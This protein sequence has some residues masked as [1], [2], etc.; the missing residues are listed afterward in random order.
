PA[1][2]GEWWRVSVGAAVAAA[3]GPPGDLWA[4]AAGDGAGG[5]APALWRYTS[6]DGGRTWRYHGT[7][8][9]VRGWVADLARPTTAAAY[10]LATGFPGATSAGAG[11]VATGDRGATWQAR[12]DPCLAGPAASHAYPSQ[13]LAAT[14]TLSLWLLCGS[15]PT[16]G[17]RQAKLVERSSD[18]G[19][20]WKAVA[21]GLPAQGLLPA[22]GTTGEVVPASPLGALLVLGG[23]HQSLLASTGG[24]S[25]WTPAAPPVVEGQG[26][27]QVSAAGGTVFV[28]TRSALWASHAG[29]WREV[30]QQRSSW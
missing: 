18:G 14:S 13:A 28:L 12:P 24:G 19:R 16:A 8:P 22:A 3:G 9:R 6:V 25:R 5:G 7:L 20:T 23:R 17:G 4:L 15:N 26:P 1:G 27:I 10:A 2:G 21:S 29:A 11:I 30:A